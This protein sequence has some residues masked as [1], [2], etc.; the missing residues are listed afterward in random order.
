[1]STGAQQTQTKDNLQ[2]RGLV[3]THLVALAPEL[4]TAGQAELVSLKAGSIEGL[5]NGGAVRGRRHWIQTSASGDGL[6]PSGPSGW[7]PGHPISWCSGG[8]QACIGLAYETCVP[9]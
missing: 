2:L 5:W 8:P 7:W 1:M 4:E 6:W 9:A 3:G